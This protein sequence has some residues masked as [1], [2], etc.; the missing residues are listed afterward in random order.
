MECRLSHKILEIFLQLVFKIQQNWGAL[1]LSFPILFT[2]WQKILFGLKNHYSRLQSCLC[3]CPVVYHP[4]H[5]SN[6]YIHKHVDEKKHFYFLA[7]KFQKNQKT[8]YINHQDIQRFEGRTEDEINVK[9]A[10]TAYL[11]SFAWKSTPCSCNRYW[12]YN[13]PNKKRT[14]LHYY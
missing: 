2:I 12:Q 9:Q 14:Q 8:L 10:R 4:K 1:G 13:H 11:P 6:M 7:K 5:V 3:I